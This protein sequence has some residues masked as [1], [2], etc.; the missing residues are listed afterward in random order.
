LRK[1]LRVRQLKEALS[2]IPDNLYVAV[3]TAENNEVDEIR[4]ECGIV[5]VGTKSIG[6]SDSDE[7][8]CK[9]YINKY[10]ESGCTRFVR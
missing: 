9:I 1:I 5:D 4:N 3:G 8:Y 6:F 7:K 10:K 2:N